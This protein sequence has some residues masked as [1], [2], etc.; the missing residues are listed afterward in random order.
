MNPNKIY[1]GNLSYG[2]TN[3]DLSAFFGQ[4]GEITELKIISDYD[5]RSKG[6]GFVTFAT[7][8]AAQASLVADGTDLQGRTIKVNL[9]RDKE[10]GGGSRGRGGRRSFHKNRRFDRGSDRGGDHGDRRW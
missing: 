9:A 7:S 3:D 2:T 4:Y 8:E 1:V 10:E 5:G 6:F